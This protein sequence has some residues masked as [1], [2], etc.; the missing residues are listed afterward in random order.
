MFSSHLSRAIPPLI[1]LLDYSGVKGEGKARPAPTGWEET[2]HFP[3]SP[4][5]LRTVIIVFPPES[6]FRFLNLNVLLGITGVPFDQ[7]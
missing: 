2:T 5:D 7:I 6:P 1:K 3:E 4:W